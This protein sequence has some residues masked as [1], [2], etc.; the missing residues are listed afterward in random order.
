MPYNLSQK[1]K[2]V[3]GLLFLKEKKSNLSQILADQHFCPHLHHVSATPPPCLGLTL[4]QYTS[5]YLGHPIHP[6]N[7]VGT[8]ADV[9]QSFGIFSVS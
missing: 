5:N 6:C 8:A 4:G 7:N 2:L 1:I 9:F 3:E